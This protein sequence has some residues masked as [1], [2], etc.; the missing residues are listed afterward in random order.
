MDIEWS[1]KK[2]GERCRYDAAHI[3]RV[4]DNRFCI[5]INLRKVR[6]KG[7]SF[8]RFYASNKDEAVARLKYVRDEL[9]AR[10]I[11]PSEGTFYTDW[12]DIWVAKYVTGQTGAKTY[13]SIIEHHIKP[14][15]L[16]RFTMKGL[17][18]GYF[19][20][21]FTKKLE[22]G[23]A[24][25]KA[26]GLSSETVRLMRLICRQSLRKAYEEGLIKDIIEI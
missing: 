8:L 11:P 20:N 21:L 17:R 23:R 26:G 2:T 25:G 10:R 6:P 14:S 13:R 15:I 18:P 5:R 4:G 3:S 12:L 16:S 9:Q 7:V 24:D 19:R 1:I 22:A